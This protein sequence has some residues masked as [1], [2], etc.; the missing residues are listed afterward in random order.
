MNSGVFFQNKHTLVGSQT[1]LRIMNYSKRVDKYCFYRYDT[2]VFEAG[3]YDAALQ[4]ILLDK[5]LT[6]VC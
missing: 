4:H 1:S 5:C 3:V 6:M 2:H